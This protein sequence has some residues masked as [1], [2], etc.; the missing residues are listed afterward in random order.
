MTLYEARVYF[1][2]TDLDSGALFRA[3]EQAVQDV[4]P[5]VTD[6]TDVNISLFEE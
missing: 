6:P 2:T 5:D 4:A 3:L 1:E